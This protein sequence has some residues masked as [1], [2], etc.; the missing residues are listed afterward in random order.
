MKYLLILIF[1]IGCADK[2]YVEKHFGDKV[3]VVS[4]FYKGC[5]GMVEGYRSY[6]GYEVD[7]TCKLNEDNV[8]YLSTVIIAKKDLE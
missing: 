6:E 1:L 5:E 3:K 8:R 4:G 7:L 2:N